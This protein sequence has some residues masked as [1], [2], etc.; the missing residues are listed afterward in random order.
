[1]F[2]EGAFEIEVSGHSYHVEAG[3]NKTKHPIMEITIAYAHED[4]I[5]WLLE[6]D[7]SMHLEIIR[8]KIQEKEI[9]ISYVGNEPH[10]FLRFGYF[11]DEIPFMNML[12][13]SAEMRGKGMG[14]KLVTYWEKEMRRKNHKML[15]TS[16]QS[17]ENA[18]HFYRKLGYRD[19]GSLLLPKEAL[20]II[21]IKDLG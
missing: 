12:V 18:Q 7:S 16:T 21:F 6:R 13:I 3:D 20:E 11:W 8:R 1:M 4:A 19:A 5:K 17:D 15:M 10:G 14:K 9:L 2:L